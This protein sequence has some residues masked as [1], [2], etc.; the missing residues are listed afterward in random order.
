MKYI[1]PLVDEGG[2]IKLKYDFKREEGIKVVID[3]PSGVA[4]VESDE[5]IPTLEDKEDVKKE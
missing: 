5:K 2:V 4:I 3:I 1:V